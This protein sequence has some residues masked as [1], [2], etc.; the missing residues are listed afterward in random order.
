M[1]SQI[2]DTILMV[3]P[4]SFGYNP[5]TAENNAFQSNATSLSPD[6]IST[7]AV[8]EFDMM[9]DGLLNHGVKVIVKDDTAN[10]RKTDAVFPNNW[11]TT[12]A[13]GDM[14]LF[15]MFSANRRLERREDIIEGLV[16]DFDLKVNQ[17]ILEGEN[18]DRFLEGT[19][20]MILDRPNQIIYACISER[21]H[22]NLLKRYAKTID[23]DVMAFHAVDDSGIPYYH[24]NVIM[25]LGENVAILCTESI[26]NDIERLAVIDRLSKTEK[27]LIEI[28]RNQ[29]LTFA[30]NM[31]EVKG[32]YS[33]PLMIM[34]TAAFNSL[35]MS[36]KYIIEKHNVIFHSPLPTIEKF[37]GGSARCMMAEIFL[38]E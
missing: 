5:E 6:N 20:S 28:S 7:L 27:E 16:K 3:R 4:K 24:T 34:S 30:G 25:A 18:N 9:V 26:I 17:S 37:G 19:G 22:P 38:K 32:K 13:A 15:P 33:K 36:Q 23:Y 14:Y 1:E 8:E 2:T 12:H 11:F 29:V 10:P 31:L 35:N 21:T